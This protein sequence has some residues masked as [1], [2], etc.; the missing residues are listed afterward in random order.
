MANYAALQAMTPAR[1]PQRIESAQS[2]AMSKG[3]LYEYYRRLGMLEVF[4]ALYPR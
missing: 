2:L 4:F 1:L 3:E